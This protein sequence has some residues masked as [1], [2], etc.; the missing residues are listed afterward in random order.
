MELKW[1]HEQLRQH[2]VKTPAEWLYL[3]Q[4]RLLGNPTK[5]MF[6]LDL[7]IQRIPFLPC[8]GPD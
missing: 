3:P 5:T 4:I 8:L 7:P 1:R 2:P 6:L